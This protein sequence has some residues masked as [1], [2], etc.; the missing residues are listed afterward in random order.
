MQRRETTTNLAQ[1]GTE[2]IHGQ[3]EVQEQVLQYQHVKTKLFFFLLIRLIFL[4]V[5]RMYG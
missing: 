1:M 4:D 2:L 5:R 3:M